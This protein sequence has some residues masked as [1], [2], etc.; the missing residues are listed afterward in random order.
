MCGRNKVGT[1]KEEEEEVGLKQGFKSERVTTTFRC[2]MG[3]SKH[4]LGSN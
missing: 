4:Y 2:S 3:E 1:G